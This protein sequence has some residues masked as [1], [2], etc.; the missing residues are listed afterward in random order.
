MVLA[1]K[2]LSRGRDG[3]ASS[4]VMLSSEELLVVVQGG[5]RDELLP[6]HLLGGSFVDGRQVLYEEGV[7]QGLIFQW[8]LGDLR[9]CV[10]VEIGQALQESAGSGMVPL[11][12]PRWRRV[13]A[14][15]RAM[16]AR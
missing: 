16:A 12:F 11:Q 9:E 1:S 8:A 7:Q 13:Q 14:T 15:A 3:G 4:E 2:R 10:H 5:A 6:V